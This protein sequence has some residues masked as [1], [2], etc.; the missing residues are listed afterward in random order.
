MCKR[1]IDG[2]PN[3]EQFLKLTTIIGR[4]GDWLKGNLKKGEKS[5]YLKFYKKNKKLSD[6][7]AM[8]RR[9]GS[10]EFCY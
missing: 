2:K 6:N 9:L 5:I 10:F 3:K 1:G 8:D 7:S 4:R